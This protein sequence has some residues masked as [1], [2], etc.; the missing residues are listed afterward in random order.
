MYTEQ[1]AM[2]MDLML[3]QAYRVTIHDYIS[4]FKGA[5]NEI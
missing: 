5:V 4:I 3:A 1:K 2:S